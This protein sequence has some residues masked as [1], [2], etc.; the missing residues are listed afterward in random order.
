M[1]GDYEQFYSVNCEEYFAYSKHTHI[2]TCTYK[3]CQNW[4]CK[5]T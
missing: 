3:I 5:K 4:L 2:A 1:T